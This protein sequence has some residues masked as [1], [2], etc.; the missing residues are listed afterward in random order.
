MSRLRLL[1]GVTRVTL[2][3]SAKAAESTAA[4]AGTQGGCRPGWPNF[5]LIV[6]FN[7]LPGAGPSGATS[8]P[9]VTTSKPGGGS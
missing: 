6:F 8:I 3:S 5:D 9:S 2:G 1:D 7:R 4:P